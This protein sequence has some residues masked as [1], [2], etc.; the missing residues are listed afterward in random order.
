[1]TDGLSAVLS[2]VAEIQSLIGV[3]PASAPTTSASGTSSA[4]DASTAT[5][6]ANALGQASGDS[7]P[8]GSLS[9]G[10]QVIAI[11]SKYLGTS[12][13][14]GGTDPKTGL[15]CSGFT[16]LVFKQL[17][18]DL[19]RTSGAQSTVGTAVGSL[20][21]AQPGD[22]LFFGSPVHHVGIYIGGNKMIDAPH[23]G[24][25]VRIQSVYETPTQI[26]RVLPTSSDTVA[27]ASLS[28]SGMSDSD[29]TSVLAGLTGSSSSSL[30]GSPYA[31]LFAA[32]GKRYGL[33]PA[34]LSAVAKTESSYN[35]NAVS[36]AGAEGL[37]Q[38]M[39]ATARSLG[40]NPMDPA[41][42]ING[43]AKILAD[44]L[45]SFGRV[46]LAV[47]AYNAGAGAVRKYNGVPPYAETQKYV[48]KV[49]T[50]WGQLR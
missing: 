25:R 41:Q 29:L 8:A 49:Q 2:R 4:S 40:V 5:D 46:D 30:T 45:R 21:D 44:N 3:S 50:A 35:P 22:L 17:G 20:K 11:A 12:Y 42:A 23:T 7:N 28:A 47:A 34:L 43:A 33:D 24:D 27:T 1:M 37:M 16:Q 6:F 32:A 13:R 15:D 26:R 36:A 14:W 31:A 38:L 9:P 19:P 48:Q 39:P 10:A 18:I